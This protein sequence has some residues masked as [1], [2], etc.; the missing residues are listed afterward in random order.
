MKLIIPTLAFL[1][2]ANAEGPS[3][4]GGKNKVIRRLQKAVDAS[5]D[6]E[7]RQ[8]MADSGW[9]QMADTF[10]KMFMAKARQS[11]PATQSNLLEY[12][13]KS[14]S[15]DSSERNLNC[16]SAT[17]DVPIN[18]R[19]VWGYGCWC[20][21]G[22]DL[23]QG[24]GNPVNPHDSACE[25]MQQ[26]LRC[27]RMDGVNGGYNC[28]PKTQLYSAAFFPITSTTSVGS[29]CSAQNPGDL[30]GAHICTCEMEFLNELLE[31]IWTGYVYDPS[32]THPNN[33]SGG[34]F[35]ADAN[36]PIN[37]PG[38]TDTE[39]CGVYPYRY[40]YNI[41]ERECCNVANSSYSP[42]EYQ[43]CSTGLQLISDGPC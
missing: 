34:T 7:M 21:F 40:P 29:G 16:A 14:M 13:V 8:I 15:T 1:A 42:F 2:I 3:P 25:R 41:F 9:G 33:P 10:I 31:L 4:R 22:D 12:V 39:C 32:F 28:D 27:S 20:Y 23:T 38:D 43:C 30:C 24:R 19:G 35:D 37:N 6:S 18:L 11:D 26:C 5:V 17:C 36:C